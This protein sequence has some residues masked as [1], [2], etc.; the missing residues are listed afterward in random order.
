M[1]LFCCIAVCLHPAG[2]LVHFLKNILVET[3]ALFRCFFQVLLLIARLLLLVP[4]HLILV[5]YVEWNALP[6][7]ALFGQGLE[8][9]DTV[10]C[11][12]ALVVAA[13]L[14]LTILNESLLSDRLGRGNLEHVRQTELVLLHEVE[15]VNN[16]YWNLSLLK[17]FL[18]D[19][20]CLAYLI[21]LVLFEGRV[22][23]TLVE[24]RVELLK[25][26]HTKLFHDQIIDQDTELIIRKFI[27]ESR[28]LSLQGDCEVFRSHTCVK[29]V[30]TVLFD[31]LSRNFLVV[32]QILAN[33]IY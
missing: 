2:D 27:F 22:T 11:L 15:H 17:L 9:F 30:F 10:F 3:P 32:L 31:D 24:R 7:G 5:Q 19:P 28:T 18:N 13:L 12:V 16:F 8:K 6:S 1:H 14:E 21:Q 33:Q 25:R 29:L 4:L 23:L 26:D 20:T